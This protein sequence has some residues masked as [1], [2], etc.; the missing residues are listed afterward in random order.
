MHEKSQ[1]QQSL[2]AHLAATQQSSESAHLAATQQS[3]AWSGWQSTK[4]SCA[5]D[6]LAAVS[7]GAGASVV[8]ALA[9]RRSKA[10]IRFASF[11]MVIVVVF[12]VGC[13]LVDCEYSETAAFARLGDWSQLATVRAN[14]YR[15]RRQTL[16]ILTLASSS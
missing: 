16:K 13:W 3:S 8:D 9:L 5:Y 1:P 15:S 10:E 7:A 12:C 6:T 4:I 11:V 14:S 2:L